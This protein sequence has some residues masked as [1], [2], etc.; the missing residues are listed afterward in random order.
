[1]RLHDLYET[2]AAP[3]PVD[4]QKIMPKTVSLPSMDSSYEYYRFLIAMAGHPHE[5]IPTNSVIADSP[6]AVA[7]TPCRW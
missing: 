3:M 1:M 6:I 5:D 7:Y 4:T 2:K